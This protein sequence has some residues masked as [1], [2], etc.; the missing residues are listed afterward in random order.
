MLTILSK[1]GQGYCDRL[2]RRNFL[3]IGA[4]GLGSWLAGPSGTPAAR[5][6]A[7]KH[8]AVIHIFLGGG[9]SQS[10]IFPNVDAPPNFRTSFRPIAT[11]IPGL[12]LCEHMPRLAEMADKIVFLPGVHAMDGSHQ[13]HC[14]FSGAV[15]SGPGAIREKQR[16]GGIGGRPS[17]GSY[18]AKLVGSS[19]G[20][21]PPY[22]TLRSAKARGSGPGFL[23]S[24]Y[25]PFV[26]SGQVANDLK[27]NG[28]TLETLE[29]RKQL[30]KSLDRLQTEIDA[31]G[32]MQGVDAM[33]A[34]AFGL[35][36]T[37]KLAAALSLSA[38]DPKTVDRYNTPGWRYGGR[39]FDAGVTL[40]FLRAR[41]LVE[42]GV[43]YVAVGY[44]G[45][46]THQANDEILAGKLPILDHGLATLVDDL[47][48][49]GL[50]DDVTVL[51]WGEMGRGKPYDQPRK[52][53]AT[54]ITGRGTGHHGDCAP[55]FLAGGGMSAGQMIGRLDRHGIKNIGRRVH[56]HEVLATVYHNVGIDVDDARIVD[57]AGRPRRLLDHGP[58]RE[59]T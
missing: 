16:F 43:R 22:I 2:S 41:R 39:R 59:L 48:Q 20:V 14:C 51:V 33:R 8:K 47:E 5:A 6:T 19:D 4:L 50:L 30:L 28:V 11:R 37:R 49:R 32:A 27:L 25:A 45:W 9:P 21:T 18:M 40:G 3:Q 54:G 23:G 52:D 26:P 38:E 24:G 35:I 36:G 12:P 34:A 53:P 46:D 42:A 13:P 56:N 17:Q 31:S 57:F 55:A 15:M 1:S 44:G 10:E 7:S 58:I 29:D